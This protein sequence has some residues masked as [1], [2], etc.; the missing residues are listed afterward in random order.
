MMGLVSLYNDPKATCSAFFRMVWKSAER[1]NR[2]RK[3]KKKNRALL[4]SAPP[5]SKM[6]R[7]HDNEKQKAEQK[8]ESKAFC[9]HKWVFREE[10]ATANFRAILNEQR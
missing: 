3:R 1:R 10:G 4:K 9:N 7:G 8:T 2:A 5:I 6:V